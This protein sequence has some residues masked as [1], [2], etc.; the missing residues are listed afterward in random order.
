[1]ALAETPTVF[2]ADFGVSVSFSGSTA[3][4]KGIMDLTGD[5]ILGDGPRG[6]VSA[7]DRSVLIPTM[8]LGSLTRSAAITVASVSYVVREIEE[9]QVDGV[10]TRVWLRSA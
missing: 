2:T 5:Q 10:F 6:I 3:G 4:L 7:K 1:M 8:Y 9:E